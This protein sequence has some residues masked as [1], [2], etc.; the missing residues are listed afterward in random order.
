VTGAALSPDGRRVLT[1]TDGLRYTGRIN[2]TGV[3]NRTLSS[4]GDDHVARLWEAGTGRLVAVLGTPERTV[5]CAL[6]SPDGRH[7]V[8]ADDARRVHLWDVETG[9]EVGGWAA[10]VA[11]T[12]AAI[13]PDGRRLATLD[14]GSE[15]RLWDVRAGREVAVLKRHRG[16]IVRVVFS[17][18]G[19]RLATASADG[20]ARLWNADDGAEAGVLRGHERAL[21]GIAFSPDGRWVVT[22]SADHTARVWSAAD[23]KEYFTLAGHLGA[24]TAA[25]F[26]PD[27]ARVVTASAD[28]TARV[29]PL[30][31]LPFAASRKPRELTAEERDRFGLLPAAA[32][33]D[34]AGGVPR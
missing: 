11:I 5:R 15:V 2:P 33:P 23:G 24:V 18:D 32:N 26:S 10:G 4:G 25:A 6:F 27:N 9:N 28:G 34:E 1:V 8:T 13:S 22:A 3:L 16:P 30:D 14:G 19:R 12:A 21:N 7:V 17:P 29:W 20:T 31:P